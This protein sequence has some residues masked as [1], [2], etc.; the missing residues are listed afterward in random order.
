MGN[1]DYVNLSLVGMCIDHATS[2]ALNT[3]D[4]HGK[5]AEILMPMHE[6][7]NPMVSDVDEQLILKVFF[8]DPVHVNAITINCDVKP[9][10]IDASPPKTMR[11]YANRPEF[12][13]SCVETVVPHQTLTFNDRSLK[14]KH[15][16]NGTKFDRVSSL[17]IFMVDN[18]DGKDRTF[19]SNIT[20]WG[21]LH[22][23]QIGWYV[24]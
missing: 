3:L 15:L 20:L 5:L 4:G 9:A 7:G 8:R 23:K 2:S 22:G 21:G 11:I 19:I 14:E 18:I 17:V 1:N 16:L 6:G 12:D 10:D 13:F 24:K